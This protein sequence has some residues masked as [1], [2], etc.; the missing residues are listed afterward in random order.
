MTIFAGIKRMFNSIFTRKMIITSDEL[1][2]IIKKALGQR[3][4]PNMLPLLPDSE[5]YLPSMEEVIS[6]LQ[7]DKTND[8]TYTAE[9]FDCDDFSALVKAAFIRDAYKK[10]LQRTHALGI[11]WGNFPTPH[12]INWV[13][14]SDK[15]FWFIEPQK[16]S[17]FKPGKKDGN[18]FVVIG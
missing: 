6:V 4:P 14:T 7:E 13:V 12:A 5:Y 11:I 15:Q 17:I 9:M 16:D 10:R 8:M 2:H 18:V 1:A 3:M